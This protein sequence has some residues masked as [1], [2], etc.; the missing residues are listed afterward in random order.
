M[1]AAPPPATT[2]V[3]TQNNVHILDPESSPHAISCGSATQPA[4]LEPIRHRPP[5]LSMCSQMA[6]AHEATQ[7]RSACHAPPAPSLAHSRTPR[8]AALTSMCTGVRRV[9]IGHDTDRLTLR[10]SSS[11]RGGRPPPPRRAAPCPPPPRAQTAPRSRPSPSRP[12]WRSHPR[13]ATSAGP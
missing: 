12:W 10:R 7:V 13:R 8:L 6:S 3:H 11:C 9:H 1:K 5:H 2:V 4:M